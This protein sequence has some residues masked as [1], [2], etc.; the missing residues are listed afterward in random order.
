MLFSNNHPGAI[1]SE[2]LVF[3]GLD[4]AGMA[5]KIRVDPKLVQDVLT[6]QAAITPEL[7][8]RIGRFF[9]NEARVLDGIADQL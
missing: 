3:R 4:A 8:V 5:S 7:A 6:A 2:E 9:G 1:L